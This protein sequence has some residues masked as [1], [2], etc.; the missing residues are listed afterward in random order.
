VPV[1]GS[2]LMLASGT[3][4]LGCFGMFRRRYLALA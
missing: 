3:G 1:P 2:W 4:L